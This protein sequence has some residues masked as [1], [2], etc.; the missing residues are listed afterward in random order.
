M[1]Q[2]FLKMTQDLVQTQLRDTKQGAQ[3]L[4]LFTPILSLTKT[5]CRNKSQ[6]QLSSLK[7]TLFKIKN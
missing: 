3:K 2:T 4:V 7:L 6:R 1:K 5:A